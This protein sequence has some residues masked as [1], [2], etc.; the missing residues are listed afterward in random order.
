[1]IP[2]LSLVLDGNIGDT[3]GSPGSPYRYL[4]LFFVHGS[5]AVAR[6]TGTCADAETIVKPEMVERAET[7]TTLKPGTTEVSDQETD[8]SHFQE[9]KSAAGTRVRQG[10]STESTSDVRLRTLEEF[11]GEDQDDGG[12]AAAQIQAL[13]EDIDWAGLTGKLEMV[14]VSDMTKSSEHQEEPDLTPVMGIS[15][16][17]DPVEIDSGNATEICEIHMGIGMIVNAYGINNPGTSATE[18]PKVTKLTDGTGDSGTRNTHKRNIIVNPVNDESKTTDINE[19]TEIAEVPGARVTVEEGIVDSGN[20]ATA[21][22]ADGTDPVG[23]DTTGKFAVKERSTGGKEVRKQEERRRETKDH[24]EQGGTEGRRQSRGRKTQEEKDQGRN[25][26]QEEE[27]EK[28]T[29]EQG[30]K[31]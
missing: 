1:M 10:P 21:V 2:L 12:E 8:V 14:G 7:G 28:E 31:Q 24:V 27:T 4:S 23:K 22:G 20:S 16:E 29:Q 30:S 26:G 5:E 25:K 18:K 15:E 9:P 6:P 11:L 17:P 3:P 19:D 13:Y